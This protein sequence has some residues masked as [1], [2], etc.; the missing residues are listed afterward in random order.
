[1]V[2]THYVGRH[3]AESR[4]SRQIT[5]VDPTRPSRVVGEGEVTEAEDVRRALTAARAATEGWQELDPSKRAGHL[6]AIASALEAHGE[7]IAKLIVSEVGKPIREARAEVAVA[8]G[9]AR[10]YAQHQL[11]AFGSN[12]PTGG[13]ALSFTSRHPLGIV[14]VISPFNFPLAIPMWKILPAIAYGNCVVWKPTSAAFEVASRVTEIIGEALP[15][16]L[17]GMVLGSAESVDTLLQGVDGVTFT[18]STATGLGLA[19]KC[20]ER[21]IPVQAEMGGK[22]ATT[23]LADAD[24]ERAAMGCV[25]AAFGYAGQ[26]CTATSRILIESSAWDRFLP[27]LE[28]AVYEVVVG[29]PARDETAVGPVISRAQVLRLEDAV[30]SGTVRIGNPLVQRRGA[31][32]EGFF[33][34]LVVLGPAESSDELSQEELFGPVVVA[35]PVK[36]VAEAIRIN[37]S[38]RYGLSASIYTKSL[39]SALRFARYAACGVVRTNRTTTGLDY[40]LPFGGEGQSGLGAKEL[41]VAAQDFF[42]RSRTVWLG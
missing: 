38:V 26:K 27:Y 28:R 13:A 35:I 4:A 41:G 5:T 30:R 39:D 31:D 22:N 3:W 20:A 24:F 2:R 25:A 29:D 7:E 14:G 15:P 32:G 9:V 40:A 21:A 23:V 36:D 17:I 18:G 19:A 33:T 10:F 6:S 8:V 16:G 1:V 11:M 34:D 42:T 37:N 12:F